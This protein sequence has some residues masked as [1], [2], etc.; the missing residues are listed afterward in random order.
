[1]PAFRVTLDGEKPNHEKTTTYNFGWDVNIV[2][3][4]GTLSINQGEAGTRS[5][6]NFDLIDR[7]PTPGNY[8]HWKDLMGRLIE[9]WEYIDGDILDLGSWRIIF[10]GQLD[11]PRT[12]K[13]NEY[14]IIGIKI[15]CVDHHAICDRVVINR[16]FAKDYI[17]RTIINIVKLYLKDDG[18]DWENGYVQTTTKTISINCP[19]VFCTQ[20]FDELAQLLGW[21]WY[22]GANKKFYFHE[23]WTKPGPELR[24]FYYYKPESLYEIR[25]RTDYRN[26]QVLRGV[27]DVT[28]ELTETAEPFP[29]GNIRNYTLKF[30][31]TDEIREPRIYICQWAE[32]WNPPDIRQ[33]PSPDVGLNGL[34]TDCKWYYTDGSNQIYQSQDEDPIA[35]NWYVVVKYY[36]QFEMDIV[37]TNHASINQRK[38]IEG[39]S[40]IYTD[41]MN[42]SDVLGVVL[43]GEKAT[44]LLDKYCRIARKFV[45]AS[46]NHRWKIGQI[47]DVILPTYNVNATGTNGYLVMDLKINDTGNKLLRTVVLVDGMAV[48]SW[49]KFFKRWLV[50]QNNFVI[51]EDSIVTIPYVE[52]EIFDWD[53]TLTIDSIDCLYPDDDPA[54]LYPDPDPAGLYPGTINNTAIYNESDSD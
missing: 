37:E 33:V 21:Q 30:P 51:R 36:G 49:I 2:V 27:K 24:E 8:F 32:R 47:C 39:G 12:S 7:E 46:Y 53:G 4:T 29:D 10:G 35:I 25:D 52:E 48:G 40:G 19:Y 1:M 34:D 23:I 13:I 41:V 42:G 43:A 22:I 45:V 14:P 15:A 9:V 18:I 54:G 31:V 17:H 11:E 28:D 20:V 44:A 16:G 26:Q 38:L 5:V 50:A 6:C 3:K